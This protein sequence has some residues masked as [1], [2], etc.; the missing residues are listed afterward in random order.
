MPEELQ[1]NSKKT[2]KEIWLFLIFVD[3]VALCVFGFFIYKSFFND[4]DFASLIPQSAAEEEV[5]AET[6]VREDILV[7]DT[8]LPQEE[9]P[10]PKAE[11]PAPADTKSA[12][13][14]SESKAAKPAEAP[15]EKPAVKAEPKRQS[16]FVSGTGKT[17]KVTFKYY[18]NA[19]SVSIISGF[20]MR[21]PVA[22]KKSG[23]VWSTT[24]V[25]YPGEY[26]YMFM[27]DGK[28]TPD[29][30]AEQDD[31]RSVVVIK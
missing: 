1:D 18:G 9:A 22:L 19:K 12:E 15:A 30:N 11:E 3:I 20:T 26:R 27:V 23:G 8:K 25:I 4:F 28:E 2:S 16:V 14:P 21:K 31:G 24:L 7:E 10:A 6:D 13:Q 29:P 5:L 17:R